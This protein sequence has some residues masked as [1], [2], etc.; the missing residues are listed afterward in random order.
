M[1][2]ELVWEAFKTVV[3]HVT[4]YFFRYQFKRL[5]LEQ[6]MF[7]LALFYVNDS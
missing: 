7:G 2:Y 5:S 6:N 1:G 4:H 3:T